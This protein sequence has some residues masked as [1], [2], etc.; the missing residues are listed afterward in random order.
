MQTVRRSLTEILLEVTDQEI[1]MVS[2]EEL[3]RFTVAQGISTQLCLGRTA[4]RSLARQYNSV[5]RI[6][7]FWVF[8]LWYYT[9][10]T[11]TCE[12]IVMK[13][14]LISILIKSYFRCW[15]KW[16]H[17]CVINVGFIYMVKA[18]RLN[19]MKA[20]KSKALAA[21]AS[22]LGKSWPYFFRH[23]NIWQT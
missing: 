19:A 12:E 20:S 5:Q 11:E 16:I 21:I 13:M 9:S 17:V 3:A 22:G 6:S 10:L 8:K 23:G 7:V 15:P 14:C 18:S 1:H 2:Q 4:R